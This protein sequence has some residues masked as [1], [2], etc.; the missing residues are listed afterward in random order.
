MDVRSSSSQQ[1]MFK[2][3]SV[4]FS[5][6]CLATVRWSHQF[7]KLASLHPTHI[8]GNHMSL[9]TNCAQFHAVGIRILL[10]SGFVSEDMLGLEASCYAAFAIAKEKK[11]HTIGEWLT[12]PHI[13]DII[14]REEKKKV[15]K[16]YLSN[17]TVCCHI[18]VMSSDIWDHVADEIWSNKARVSFQLT[19]VTNLSLTMYP[20]IL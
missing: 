8:H 5:P 9:Q 20:L 11:A 1:M 17:H 4:F 16:M 19:G 12:K 18:S 14:E 3:L 6:K 2:N 7:C 13:M 10:L 15:K